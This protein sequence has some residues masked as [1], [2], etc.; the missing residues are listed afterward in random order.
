MT[1]AVDARW[2]PERRLAGLWRFA[3][4]IS[5]V[6][7]LGH[8]LLGFEQPAAVPFVSLATAYSVELLL[9][10]ISAWGMGRSP[11]YRGGPRP[12]VDFLLPA[13][14][15]ALAVG[16]LLYANDSLWLV[17]FSSALAIASKTI[18]RVPVGPPGPNGTRPTRHVLNPSNMAISVTLLLF[19]WV[20]AAP[21][22]QFVE[23]VTG[24]W[25]WF[26]TLLLFTSGTIVNTRFTGRLPV[27]AS[28]W[29]GFA[30][31][32]IARA[33]LNGTPVLAT[34]APMTGIGFVLF[35]FYMITDPGTTPESPKSQIAFGLAV[36]ALYGAIVQSHHIFGIYYS[37]T[38]V[39][40]GRGGWLAYCAMRVRHTPSA[41]ITGSTALAGTGNVAAP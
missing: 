11:R 19:P 37:L 17:A 14:I 10:A 21:P 27:I 39:G 35:S 20:T 22:Y 31:Q 12:F 24:A 6:N 1:K 23:N 8:S 36:A 30:A 29:A 33:L 2:T 34:L 40:L 16:M 32:G 18:L 13:H 25:D 4:A 15:S 3:I 41:A 9:E 38:L 5:V 7:L 28:W 26:L